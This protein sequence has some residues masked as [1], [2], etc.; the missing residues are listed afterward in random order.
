MNETL[1]LIFRPDIPPAGQIPTCW[2]PFKESEIE[3]AI[4]ALHLTG[5]Y[6]VHEI[7]PMHSQFSIIQGLKVKE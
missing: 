5:D 4:D 3:G 6:E 7:G 2:G 1:F